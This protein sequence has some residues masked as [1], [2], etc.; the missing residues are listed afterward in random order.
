LSAPATV[1]VI[2]DTHLPRGN[3]RL[4][5]GCVERLRAADLVI[6]AGDFS[7]SE[8]LKELETLTAR[9]IGVHGNVDD[10]EVRRRLPEQMEVEVGG[11]RIGVIHDAGPARGRL[12]RMRRLFPEADAV[13]F[14]HSHMPLLE[15]DAEGF[16]IFNPGSPTERRRAPV[17]AMGIARIGNEG[18]RFEHV[19]LPSPSNRI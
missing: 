3:R 9:L 14:G 13:I 10:A 5:D 2:A 18:V 12:A 11:T 16:Q 8:A 7:T 17:H 19:E 6:H 4:P 15:R 1:A